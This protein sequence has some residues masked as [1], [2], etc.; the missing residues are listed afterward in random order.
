[1][2]AKTGIGIL[3][4]IILMLAGLGSLSLYKVIVCDLP[5]FEGCSEDQQKDGEFVPGQIIVRFIPGTTLEAE[6]QQAALIR[7]REMGY[8]PLAIDEQKA[9][10][11]VLYLN[12]HFEGKPL[13]EEYIHNV[14]VGLEYLWGGKVQL[15]TT[16]IKSIKKAEPPPQ[17]TLPG[18]GP[19]GAPEAAGEP[20]IEW[21]RVRYTMKDRKMS[22]GIL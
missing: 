10:D 14:L 4:A 17:P 21:Q 2:L 7:L 1:M 15:E 16:Q 13:V 9:A 3:V 8:H 22:K 20:E 12:H 6:S 18:M 19:A 5:L 11:G